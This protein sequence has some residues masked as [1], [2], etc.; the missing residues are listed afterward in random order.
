VRPGRTGPRQANP[1]P[2]SR[3]RNS[4]VDFG[5]AAAGAIAFG[6][7]VLFSRIVAKNGLGPLTALGVRFGV[8][9]LL[10]LGVL[11][12]RRRSLLPPP[13]E[14]LRAVLLGVVVYALESTCF[15]MAL[16]RGTAAAVTLLFYSYPAVVTGV[17][18]MLGEV[19]PRPS[20]FLA[21]ALSMGGAFAVAAGGGE[22]SIT[23][24]GAGF[25]AGSVVFFSCYALGSAR[26]LHRTDSLTAAAW[27]AVGASASL[28]T[29]GALTG[30]LHA[31]GSS[32]PPLLGNGLATATAFTLFFVALDRLGA[33][34]TAVIMT[35]EA[36]SAVVLT[37]VF[38][39]EPLRLLEVI[40]GLAVLAGAALA[41]LATPAPTTTH[42][43]D[44][45]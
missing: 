22:V 7:T 9:A 2:T 33:S 41:G 11:A 17:E 20:V 35:L 36:A 6:T 23:L 34:R 13:G 21:L 5:L 15:F 37:A 28:L 43:V 1:R 10:L 16:E 32:L 30:E 24:A 19:V 29:V 45:P 4:A 25:V 26:L 44:P 42:E 38:L 8:A 40:G 39:G 18:L 27:T 31:P 12:V 3:H 14:R